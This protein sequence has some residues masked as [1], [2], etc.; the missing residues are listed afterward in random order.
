MNMK[1]DIFDNIP[2]DTESEIPSQKELEKEIS[3]YLSK[4]YGGTIKVY[5]EMLMS[6]TGKKISEIEESETKEED[7]VYLNFFL[8][9]QE[10]EAYLNKYVIKQ[11]DAKAI[12]ATKICTHFN[13]I[14]YLKSR[15]EDGPPVG[16]IK[17]NIILIGPTG[18]GKTYLIKLIAKKLGVP[19]VKG[20]ATKFSETGYV[21]GDVED[22]V[23]ELVAEADGNIEKAQYG[24]IYLDEIDKIAA[25]PYTQGPDVSRAGVQRT[26][27]KPLEETEVEIKNF[28]DPFFQFEAFDKFKR[29]DKKE[30]T[31]INTRNILFIVSGAFS[32]LKDIIKKRVF[33]K[34]I[35][36][37]AD[38][39]DNE[40]NKWL[41]MV[42]PQDLIEYGFESE[43]IGRLPVVAV[44]DELT[45]NDLYEI[46]KNPNNPII[47]AKRQDF[48]SYG[49]DIR[50]EDVILRE[51]AK[52]GS[53]EGTGARS[54]VSVIER[55]LLPFEKILPSTDVKQLLVTMDMISDNE[56]GIE[57]GVLSEI[58]LANTSGYNAILLQERKK[59]IKNIY[60]DGI[61]GFD[62]SEFPLT[63][64]R[65][66]FVADIA[67]EKD[68][69]VERAYKDLKVIFKHIKNYETA[70]LNRCNLSIVFS[71]E[72]IDKLLEIYFKNPMNLYSQCERICNVL[73]YGLSLVR[74]RARQHVFLIPLEAV[75][76]TEWYINKLIKS[77][78][79]SNF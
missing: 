63:D 9:P 1:K 14:R 76:N 19:F 44:L 58:L 78:Y 65:I 61:N 15:G 33:R 71:D 10:L 48:L 39:D 54:L 69:D 40:D 50:F 20:D 28:V 64:K 73:E 29:N 8:K 36:F 46:L 25:S 7:D 52:K 57:M 47:K 70:F 37:R 32:G 45:E 18:V 67:L 24:I 30:Q 66:E 23:R 51:F 35:G 6:K 13:R 56:N 59:I 53:E 16:Y 77:C 49:I 26:L 68:V 34:G 2:Q 43:F 74:E 38:I 27:L 72:A 22:L 75:E 62:I 41:R 21:G 79:N 5:S 11:D 3:D 60:K 42:K 4:K 17:N 31:T 55:S 12:L